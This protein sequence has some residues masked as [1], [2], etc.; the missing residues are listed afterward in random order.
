MKIIKEIYTIR[1][2]PVLLKFIPF[3]YKIKNKIKFLSLLRKQLISKIFFIN[4]KDNFFED[5]MKNLI[6]CQ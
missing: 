5:N 4:K 3:L 1:L 6:T 2:F